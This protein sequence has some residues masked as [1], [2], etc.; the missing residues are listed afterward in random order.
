MTVKNVI[1]A[2]FCAFILNIPA[3]RAEELVSYRFDD[4]SL[5]EIISENDAGRP[6]RQV[7]YAQPYVS[8]KTARQGLLTINGLEEEATQKFITQYSSKGGLSWL[9]TVMKRGEPYQAFIRAEIAKRGMPAEL[10]Y[11]PVIE[12]AY[13]Y[14]AVSRAGAVGIWQFM[15]NSIAG[16]DMKINDWMD[17][18]RDFWKS[19]IGAL[20]KLSY[21]YKV[22]GSWELALAAY[23]CGLGTV[24]RAQKKYPGETYW[25]LC[26]RKGVF[27][28]QTIQYV[29]RFL[30]VSHILSNPREFG[31]EASWPEDPE[32]TQIAVGR[33]VDLGLVAQHAGLEGAELKKANGELYYGITP[34][35]PN[36]R[37]KA[38]K[39]HAEAIAGVLENPE[40]AL[41]K[42]YF[43]TIHSGDTLSEIAE[44][45]GI[46]VNQIMS[47][48]PGLQARYLKLGQRII[49]P[50]L[51]DV[52]IDNRPKVVDHVSFTGT[53]LVKKG[54]TLW[55]IALAYNTD[56][57]TLAAVN[58]MG[59]NET[60]REGR[61]LKTP[62]GN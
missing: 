2:A 23:N 42:Y 39:A 40:L 28:Q 12:S 58:N 25:D 9:T 38:P 8:G 1:L 19:T 4:D 29:P 47:Y 11:L 14:S 30:A 5:L 54:E 10:I 31:L 59:L 22:T 55:S 15:R 36:Y 26:K 13:S 51:R 34:P 53:H 18:R 21:N 46:S 50:A 43:H 49:I 6:L 16:Y 62:V 57:E 27:K 33:S 7:R 52:K 24:T 61:A 35:D 32:W 48:N 44:R 3:A 60:L 45:Y 41:I 17:E 37:I 56:P 20:E